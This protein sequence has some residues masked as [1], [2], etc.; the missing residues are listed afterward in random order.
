LIP[1]SEYIPVVF[2]PVN[3]NFTANSG[4]SPEGVQN[5]TAVNITSASNGYCYYTPS[6]SAGVYYIFSAY[7]KG[8]SGET[9]RMRTI[10]DGNTTEKLVTLTGDWQREEISVTGGNGSTLLYLYD[11]RLG[12]LT[13]TNFEVWGAQIEAGSYATSYIPTYGSSVSRVADASSITSASDLIGQTE[14]SFYAEIDFTDT[15]ADQMYM[16]LSDGTSANRIHI[17]YDSTSNW[18]YCNVKAAN[19]QQALL[20][21]ASPSEGI[22]KIAVTYAQDYYVM[23]IN[24]SQISIDGNANVPTLTRINI[25]GYFSTGFEYPVRQN[26][27][28][29]TRL[30]NEELAALTTI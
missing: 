27:L 18:I 17:G 26:L 3:S 13:A 30:S 16:T 6:T 29:K 10:Y 14:G 15:D 8:T 4:I 24:G 28:F 1:N 7:Y 19:L 12:N 22:K 20:T 21:S 25:G 11:G 9:L 5:S 2:S 23:Y